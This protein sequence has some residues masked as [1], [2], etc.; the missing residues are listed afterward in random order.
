MGRNN[1]ELTKQLDAFA[2]EI[3]KGFGDPCRYRMLA[4]FRQAWTVSGSL[5][6]AKYLDIQSLN[7]E[8]ADWEDISKSLVGGRN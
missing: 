4:V 3:Q 8:K 5:A 7:F 1:S 2:Q 6:I